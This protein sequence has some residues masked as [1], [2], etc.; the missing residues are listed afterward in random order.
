MTATE[1][2]L[3]THGAGSS[4]HF[5]VVLPN[6][7]RSSSPAAIR[8]T[9]AAAEE[10][11]FRSVW[12]TEH[13]IVGPEGVDRYVPTFDPFVTLSWIAGWTQQVELG[14]SILLVA[15]HNPIHVA[16][17]VATLTELTGRP[18]RL[19]VGAGWHEDEFRFMG[20]GFADRGR[21]LD[22]A[23]RLMRALWSGERSFSGDYW[24]L[25]DATFSP[26]PS[27]QPELWVGGVSAPSIRRIE[28]LGDATWHPSSNVDM[29]FVRRIREEHPEI[30]VVPR[31]TPD[32]V[33]E[34]LELGA[35]GAIVSF[36]DDASMEA[37][38]AG[39]L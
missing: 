31:T 24:Q 28:L 11:G 17:Q 2:D 19:G 16:K 32:L 23:V 12:A 39:Y 5:G 4:R 20:M 18:F 34:F 15:L 3:D 8:R 30:R 36:P 38:A 22:E 27:V 26:L 10:L 7:G 37:F 13:I 35:G 14:T 6:Y 9:A 29:D 25:E 33:D 21:R 1:A